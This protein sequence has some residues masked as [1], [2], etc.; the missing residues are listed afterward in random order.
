MAFNGTAAAIAGVAASAVGTGVSYYEGQQAVSANQKAQQQSQAN[1]EAQFEARQSADATALQQQTAIS[2]QNEANYSQIEQDQQNA[3]LQAIQDQNNQLGLIN[4]QQQ[5]ISDQHDN[6]VQQAVQTTT[7]PSLAQAQQQL[8]ANQEAS[9]TPITQAILTNNPLGNQDAGS[10]RVQE[11]YA[12]ANQNAAKYVQNYGN[13]QAILAGYAAP[14]TTANLAAQNLNGALLT[15]A[16]LASTIQTTAPALLAPYNYEYTAAGQAGQAAQAANTA[17]TGSANSL[18]KAQL[19]GS[20]DLADLAQQDTA[21]TIQGNL[22]VTQAQDAAAA[23][24]GSGLASLGN[25]AIAY[26]SSKGGLSQLFGASTA[27]SPGGTAP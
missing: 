7:A 20:T 4:T 2:T 9:E 14:A 13:N 22:N 17:L 18:S 5:Q 8:T 25:S 24:L 3:Q 12:Q 27:A 1:Q 23:S 21:N 19:A 11:A 26:G 16:A 6:A 15:P 10:S